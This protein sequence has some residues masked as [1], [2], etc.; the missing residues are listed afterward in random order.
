M[1]Y[2]ILFLF[3]TCVFAG[4]LEHEKNYINLGCEQDTDMS[5]SQALPNLPGDATRVLW[6]AEAAAFR[7]RDDG[8]APTSSVG[9]QQP[10]GSGFTFF[11]SGTLSQVRIIE[12]STSTIL[13][14]CYYK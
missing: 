4:P 2:L 8:G 3:S 7:W 6:Q 13:N 1:K 12:E 9:M 14:V 11:Y 5:S 10:A